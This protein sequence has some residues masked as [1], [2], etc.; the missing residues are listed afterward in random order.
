MQ[1]AARTP[2]PALA[3]AHLDPP[4]LPSLGFAGS[5]GAGSSGTNPVAPDSFPLSEDPLDPFGLTSAPAPFDVPRPEI[6]ISLG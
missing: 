5:G 6:P 3:L 4:G 2:A 1:G